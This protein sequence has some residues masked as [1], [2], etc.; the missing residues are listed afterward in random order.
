MDF[1]QKALWFVESNSRRDID[2][3]QVARASC[4]SPY[5]LIRA[6][7]EVF[8]VSLMRYVRI[9]RLSE[10]AKQ[11]AAGTPDILSIALDYGYGSH[12]A[13]SRAFK[14]EFGMTPE[15]VRSG[16]DLSQLNVKEPMVVSTRQLPGLNPPRLESLSESSFV[17]LVERYDSQSPAGIPN[18]WQQ[19]APYLGTIRS[20]IGRDAFG[21][22]FNFDEEGKFDYMSGVTVKAGSDSPNGL[23]RLTVPAQ[24]YAVF[25]HKGHITDIRSVIA[26]IWSV[27]L[28]EAGFEPVHGPTL[29]RYGP[30]FDGRTGQGGYEIWVA[31]K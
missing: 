13:F 24:K 5:H 15:S 18:Q 31:V 22:C 27:G 17:G 6:F 1:V 7:A 3:E 23:V 29:E 28:S 16:A 10:A 4:V 19:F 30:E 26:A 25:H 11:L 9:R 2:L 21:V 8:G 14:K 12:E 20:Q